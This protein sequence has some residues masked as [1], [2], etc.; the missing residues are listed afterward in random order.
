MRCCFVHFGG[1]VSLIRSRTNPTTNWPKSADPSSAR[2]TNPGA[3]TR[4][5]N[6][7]VRHQCQRSRSNAIVLP[8]TDNATNSTANQLISGHFII[9]TAFHVV[10]CMRHA[11]EFVFCIHLVPNTKLSDWQNKT[12]LCAIEKTM[13]VIIA[14]KFSCLAK[15]LYFSLYDKVLVKVNK[16]IWIYSARICLYLLHTC[17]VIGLNWKLCSY[18]KYRQ[19]Q[20][21]ENAYFIWNHHRTFDAVNAVNVISWIAGE[22]QC[23]H[24]GQ[25]SSAYL[26]TSSEEM[27]FHK[28]SKVFLI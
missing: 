21:Y 5:I 24:V 8:S 15:L 25:L 10:A 20:L 1:F 6:I 17:S 28:K 3:A 11:F 19:S 27:C 23:S 16:I 14:V 13:F 4:T 12:K 2:T 18:H 7:S 9:E 26:P 22:L